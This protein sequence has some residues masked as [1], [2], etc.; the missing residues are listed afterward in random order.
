MMLLRLDQGILDNVNLYYSQFLSNY[1]TVS[2]FRPG[3]ASVDGCTHCRVV[4][5]IQYLNM[6]PLLA[7][8]SSP[9]LT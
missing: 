1:L 2:G 6:Q 5:I 8:L 9:N 7:Q 3:V 4:Y